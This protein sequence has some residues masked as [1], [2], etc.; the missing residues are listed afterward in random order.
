MTLVRMA[1]LAGEG[2]ETAATQAGTCSCHAKLEFARI[3]G[4]SPQPPKQSWSRP[5]DL[6]HFILPALSGRLLGRAWVPLQRATDTED[7]SETGGSLETLCPFSL[8]S[9]SLLRSAVCHPPCF[10]HELNGGISLNR[11]LPAVQ[12][13]QSAG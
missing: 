12:V 3:P 8:H 9:A 13:L 10:F 5:Q 2:K 7:A 4:Q 11:V 6:P 1:S